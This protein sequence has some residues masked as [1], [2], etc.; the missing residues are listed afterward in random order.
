MSLCK[1][2]VSDLN[3]I[4]NHGSLFDAASQR[5]FAFKLLLLHK[6]HVLYI[7][8]LKIHFAWYKAYNLKA[9]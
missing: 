3:T 4:V 9:I 2:C 6:T 5:N 7:L 1:R 8:K